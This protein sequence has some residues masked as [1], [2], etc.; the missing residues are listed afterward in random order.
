MRWDRG[1]ERKLVCGGKMDD[2][3]VPGGA[4]LGYEDAGDSVWI[5]RI[6]SE[7]VDGLG[8]EGD[9]ATGSEEFGGA[10]DIIGIGG[11]EVKC[12]HSG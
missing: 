10:G 3:R 9:E 12:L 1:D 11:V 8:G 6:G 2:E 7:A 4:L 5:Q